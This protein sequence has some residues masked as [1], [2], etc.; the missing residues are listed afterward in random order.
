M[1]LA[2]STTLYGCVTVAVSNTL[3]GCVNLLSLIPSV[4]V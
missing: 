3:Y 2:V 1:N 4:L